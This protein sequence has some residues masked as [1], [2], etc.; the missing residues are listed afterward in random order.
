MS[1]KKKS[2]QQKHKLL[3]CVNDRGE[4]KTSCAGFGSKS[5]RRYAKEQCEGRADIEVKKVGCLGLCKHGPV[6]ES[7]PAKIYYRCRDE[8]DID[9]L[10]RSL[11]NLHG[12]AKSLIISTRKSSKR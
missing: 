12:D 8:D 2:T 5:L 10:L 6:I 1:K 4:G 3:F 11:D 7:V 9:L